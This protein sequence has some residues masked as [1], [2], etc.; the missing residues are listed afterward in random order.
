MAG[1]ALGAGVMRSA[2]GVDAATPGATGPVVHGPHSP[3]PSHAAGSH[4]T[5]GGTTGGTGTVVHGPHTPSPSHAPGTTHTTGGGT[6][7]GT[8]TVVHGPH[9]P[10]PSRAP[11]FH[12]AP[13]GTPPGS[14][15]AGTVSG[16]SANDKYVQHLYTDLVGSQDPSGQAFWSSQLASGSARSDAAFA[17]TQTDGYRTL[18]VTALYQKV[19]H[20]PVDGPGLAYWVGRMAQGLTPE[21]LA[22]SLVGS[23]EMFNN[24]QFGNGQVDTYVSAV[25][26]SMLGRP[27]DPPGFAFWRDF[28]NNGGPAW[29]LTLDFAYSPEWAAQ[30]VN[31]MFTQYH[32]GT[33][34][35][36]GLSFWQGKVLNGLPD[37]QLAA[38]VVASDAYFNWA[39][40]H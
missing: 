36:A 35:A 26:R 6:T 19:M 3:S 25:Y 9:T 31:R 5:G 4:T 29:K 32:L 10:S 20:R 22:A 39:Q 38:S 18:T 28:M 33:P 40:T 34:D 13:G 12:G 17:L 15:P 27:A 14:T 7:G 8:G 21:Q 1:T 30:T 24:P 2:S 11:G 16:A 37:D 23:Q